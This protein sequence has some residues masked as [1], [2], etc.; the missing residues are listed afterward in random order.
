MTDVKVRFTGRPRSRED[1]SESCRARCTAQN[2]GPV[3]WLWTVVA[4]RPSRH[5]RLKA[6]VTIHDSGE[7]A[8]TDV[9][10]SGA[11]AAEFHRL[12]VRRSF[13]LTKTRRAS[14]PPEGE[15]TI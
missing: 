13:G 1:E 3:F 6:R 12:P 15:G 8:T 10:H 2:P 9:H 4:N 7:F 11:S 5:C 14:Q